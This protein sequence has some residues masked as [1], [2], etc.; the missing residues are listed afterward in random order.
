MADTPTAVWAGH[1]FYVYAQPGEREWRDVPGVYIMAGTANRWW[2]A[3][4]IGQTESF[5]ARLDEHERWSEAA[6]RGATHIHACVVQ[7]AAQRLAMEAA[8]IS[9]YD[10]PMNRRG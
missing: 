4:Y 10:P 3:H 7:D 2:Q 6:E 9:A 5:A 1:T 8:L